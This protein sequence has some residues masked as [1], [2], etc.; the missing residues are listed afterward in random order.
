MSC[1]NKLQS[2]SF[3]EGEHRPFLKSP[4]EGEEEL[5]AKLLLAPPSMAKKASPDN[6]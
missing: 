6:T 1:R 3:P 5:G 2:L 4:G